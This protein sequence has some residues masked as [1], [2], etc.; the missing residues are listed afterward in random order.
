[1]AEDTDRRSEDFGRLGRELKSAQAMEEPQAVEKFALKKDEDYPDEDDRFGQISQGINKLNER[2]EVLEQREQRRQ[3]NDQQREQQFIDT[4]VDSFCDG[5]SK[6][7]PEFGEAKT[8]SRAQRVIREQLF[9]DAENIILGAR[10][11]G[12][13]ID[14]PSAMERAFSIYEGT[15]A[16]TTV[17]SK[18]VQEAKTRQKQFTSRP[19]KRKTTEK[20]STPTEKAM[21]NYA[22][23]LSAKGVR[24]PDDDED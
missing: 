1:M 2:F 11:K 21:A 12:Q 4:T 6:E 16:K 10:S 23:A 22:K 18:L 9:D 19:T 14:L 13:N 5:K 15:N 24:V 3:K 7:Y 17:R 20:Y 8:L